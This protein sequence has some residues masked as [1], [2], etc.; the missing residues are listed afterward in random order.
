MS[1][2]NS[3]PPN[4]ASHAVSAP[5]GLPASSV[6]QEAVA[7]STGGPI[8]RVA[9]WGLALVSGFALLVG[10][11]ALTVRFLIWP[12][13]D[14]WRPR[15]ESL[16]STQF[17]AR[18]SIDALE[19]GFQGWRPMLTVHRL[20]VTVGQ[21]EPEWAFE[22]AHAVLSIRA[23]LSGR[24]ELA[25]LEIVD[26]VLKAERV[27]PRRWLMGGM[28]ID[29]DRTETRSGGWGWLLGT[30]TF[31]LR[32]LRVD[33]VD[34]VGGGV[35]VLDGIELLAERDAGR[36]Q[37]LINV[38]RLAELAAGVELRLDANLA[39]GANPLL[40]RNWRGE[41]HLRVGEIDLRQLGR[42]L[43]RIAQPPAWASALQG[44]RGP[45]MV[46]S[47][48][49]EGEWRD[50]LVKTR[51]DGLMVASGARALPLRALE[52]EARARRGLGPLIELDIDRL[53]ATDGA[54]LVIELDDRPQ[55]VLFDSAQLA[56]VELALSSKGFDAGALLAATQRLPLP[57]AWQRALEHWR[58][59]GRVESV[60]LAWR[61][62]PD[63]PDYTLRL[64]VQRLGLRNTARTVAN[65]PGLPSAS[66]LSGRIELDPTGG[67]AWIDSRQAVLT[68]PGV[69]AQP[70]LSFSALAGEL[71][72][73]VPAAE[74]SPESP[75][76]MGGHA[77]EGLDLNIESLRFS[78][79]DLAGQVSGRYRYVTSGPGIVDLR[80][81]LTR[82]QASRVAR[83][84]PI[85]VGEE[86]R[87]WVGRSVRAGQ[88][89]QGRFVLRGDLRHFPFRDPAQ[90][91][92]WVETRLTS[93]Q[94]QFAPDWPAIEAIEARL[95]F[96][97]GS[98]SIGADRART[99]GV[100]LSGVTA[101]IDDFLKPELKLTGL[102]QGPA[103]RMMDFL[104]NSPLARQ[105][106]PAVLDFE[107]AALGSLELAIDMPL[108][109]G[110]G[111]ARY[112]GD[113]RL[114]EGRLLLAQDMPPLESLSANI[115]F[116]NELF[117]IE[118]IRA[119]L[120]GGPA[121][122]S[123]RLTRDGRLRVE[124][125]G[126][127]DAL[128]LERWLSGRESGLIQGGAG[129]RMVV[130]TRAGSLSL[131]LDSDLQGLASRL[132][133][134]LAKA[135]DEIWPLQVQ[136][137][138]S[139]AEAPAIEQLRARLRG[140]FL[141][142]TERRQ[143]R[144]TGRFERVR[145]SLSLGIRADRLE[146]GFAV[147]AHLPYFD[148]DAWR[149][150]WAQAAGGRTDE[151]IRD[152]ATLPEPGMSG[153]SAVD[154]L[155]LSADTTAWAGRMFGRFGALGERQG[156]SWRFR[157]N[158]EQG[159]GVVDW[160]PPARSGGAGAVIARLA[161]LEI[162]AGAAQ[163]R[164]G[165]ALDLPSG[166]LPAL[167]LE[168]DRLVLAGRPLGALSLSALN[169]GQGAEAFWRLDRL[170]L[171]HPGGRLSAS[172][173]WRPLLPSATGQG[174]PAGGLGAGAGHSADPS[175]TA[176]A[177]AGT[178][179]DFRLALTDP[180]RVLATFGIQGALAGGAGAL[181]GRLAWDGSPL[182]IHYPSVSGWVDIDLGR[183]QFL[184]TEPGLAKLIGVLNLQSLPRRLSLDFRDVF[185]EGFAFDEIRGAASLA[186]GVA[187][188]DAFTMRGVQALVEIRGEANLTDETQHL[189]IRV[190]PELNAGLASLAYAA[191]ANPAVGL[192]SFFAQL[193][194]RKPLRD[195]FSYEYEV[196][197]SWTDPTVIERARPRI[198][199]P[200]P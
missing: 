26:A 14:D 38:P 136:W 17:E 57:D 56:P 80:G 153:V 199:S 129:Y 42:E 32:G 180:G 101:R 131:T 133:V 91:E 8:R 50:L 187:R 43:G 155:V 60:G 24:F 197:G 52:V 63:R 128:A 167:D 41:W 47:E 81:D 9:R 64:D 183:G 85:A 198:D 176:P 150:A 95:R 163:D 98:M 196:K 147:A 54:G 89:D 142:E 166:G 200:Q 70:A 15:L 154:R 55:R 74:S 53:R 72:W 170:E 30:R 78:N 113:L 151:P 165:P 73:R 160:Q 65:H 103:A 189:N 179:L 141:L 195:I 121:E 88:A 159:E 190:R 71:S 16:L 69:F 100:G 161:R 46:W 177:H 193:A 86:T 118:D 181:S 87:A 51:A 157:V 164:N 10:L 158:G 123:A 148:V 67:R 68:F 186:S 120:L 4:G 82:A 172:G 6:R 39:P 37:G 59:T 1:Q 77:L 21:S 137:Q 122:A 107:L 92:L 182:S 34:R 185:A 40:A 117:A 96:E 174:A 25:R 102:A 3:V 84:L 178:E 173:A 31:S 27:E 104:M 2:H 152:G 18:V 134:P 144:R 145:G 12:S 36:H 111:D 143:D 191:V 162:P 76:A 132:P 20:S 192:G 138:R 109:Q 5:A 62:R 127:A 169:V 11:T 19:P 124:A 110:A 94:L 112:Q 83:Y 13:L 175:A 149:A 135:S 33:W 75:V 116:A 130:D 119:N 79:A 90:G 139:R 114:R 194:L 108:Y 105:V 156:E 35:H 93:G 58:A 115:R 106:D 171:A 126:R 168:V 23:L 97:R 99:L 146:R 44:G 49:A 22:R 188:T 29:L 140:E 66:N 45:L 61:T 48:F 28:L 7:R 125:R 184:K